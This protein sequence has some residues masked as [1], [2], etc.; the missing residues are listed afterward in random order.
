MRPLKSIVVALVIFTAQIGFAADREISTVLSELDAYLEW[1]PLREIGVIFI[2]RDR[3]AFK[4]G[5]PFALVNY[6]EK[7]DIDPPVRGNGGIYFTENA[8]ADLK[9][10][11]IRNRFRN[12]DQTFRISTILIDP[13]HGGVDPGAIDE[14]VV[15]KQGSPFKEKDVV[16]AIARDL[17]GMLQTAFPEKKI[18]LTRESDTHVDLEQRTEMA[19]D[20]LSKTSDSVLFISIHAN[21]SL[22]TKASGFE[23][24]CLPPEYKRTLLDESSVDKE[25]IDLLS[26]LNSMKEEEISVESFILAND[27]LQ[28]IGAKVGGLTDNRRLKEETWFVVRNAKMPAVL[29]EVGFLS[30]PQEVKRLADPLYLKDLAEGMFNGVRSFISRFENSGSSSAR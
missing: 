28:G 15:G 23:V 16:L 5:V 30:N 11:L 25:N 21:Y 29:V 22:N 2:D 9:D 13:G 26:I 10:A 1:N 4:P 27:I 12:Q 24:W 18:L 20:L 17:R 3:I 8:V 6:D 7:I 14:S 19:N